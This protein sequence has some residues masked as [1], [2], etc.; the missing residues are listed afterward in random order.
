MIVAL[1]HLAAGLRLA[2]IVFAVMC[3]LA[4]HREGQIHRSWLLMAAAILC[5]SP[6]H[7]SWLLGHPWRREVS[8]ALDALGSGLGCLAIIARLAHLAGQRGISEG[9]IRRGVI[10]NLAVL[11]ILVGVVWHSP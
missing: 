3:F 8:T 6:A 2:L 7:A 5:Y 10:V 11:L 9:R 4:W 1:M